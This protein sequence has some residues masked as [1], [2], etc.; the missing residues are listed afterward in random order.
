[1]HSRTLASVDIVG[2][3]VDKGTNQPVDGPPKNKHQPHAHEQIC[4]SKMNSQFPVP[5]KG[6]RL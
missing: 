2:K 3:N 1:M 4:S 6:R 5:Q